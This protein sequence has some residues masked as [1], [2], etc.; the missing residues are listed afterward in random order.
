M[1]LFHGA[2]AQYCTRG[3][4]FIQHP[5]QTHR[6]TEPVPETLIARQRRSGR[7]CAATPATQGPTR[8]NKRADG[9]LRANTQRR[10]VK[11]NSMV[12]H[13]M[14]SATVGGITRRRC[15]FGDLELEQGSR[16]GGEASGAHHGLCRG[17]D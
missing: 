12:H 7:R 5:Q 8:R 2:F 15:C 13:R 16:D 10:G 17:D 1:R 6:H 11:W 4:F 3:A 14:L 9:E